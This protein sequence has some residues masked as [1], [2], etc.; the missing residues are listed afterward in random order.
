MGFLGF[1]NSFETSK[2]NGKME[3]FRAKIDLTITGRNSNKTTKK[4]WNDNLGWK[5]EKRWSLRESG[6]LSR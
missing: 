4:L 6:A 1:Y 3:V 2:S 5:L